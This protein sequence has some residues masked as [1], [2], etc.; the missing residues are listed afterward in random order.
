MIRGL[1]Y[2]EWGE[3]WRSQVG[4]LFGYLTYFPFIDSLLKCNLD[5]DYQDLNYMAQWVFIY[6]HM[7]G[8]LKWKESKTIW[9]SFRKIKTKDVALILRQMNGLCEEGRAAPGNLE[10]GLFCPILHYDLDCWAVSGE[11]WTFSLSCLM[12]DELS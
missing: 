11:P 5:T 10:S 3:G 4:W 8:S 1:F 2:A 7:Q 6:A 12:E 9:S